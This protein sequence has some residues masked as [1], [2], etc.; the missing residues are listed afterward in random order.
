MMNA[1]IV[2]NALARKRDRALCFR[3]ELRRGD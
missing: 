1:R 3:H 2:S